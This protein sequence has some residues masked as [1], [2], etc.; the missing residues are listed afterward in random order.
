MANSTQIAVRDADIVA[1]LD[2]WGENN[3][4]DLFQGRSFQA[5]KQDAALAIIE[6]N[7]LR[8]CMTSEKGRL[9]L[10]RALQRSATSG[11][12]LNPQK[13]ESALV[14]INGEVNFWPM[15]NGIIKT[16]LET[17]ALEYVEANTIYS[18]DTFS[19]KKTAR[20]DDYDF[21]PSLKDRGFPA[22]YF[23]V[24]VLKSGRSVV[25]YWDKQQVEDHKKKYG[26]GLTNPKSAW[27]N[28]FDGMAEK[29]VLKALLAGLHL[30][31][32]VARLIEMDNAVEQEP[33]RDV[34]ETQSCEK[35]ADAGGIEAKLA[36]RAAADGETGNG[37]TAAPEGKPASDEALF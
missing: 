25:E 11:L 13:G 28:N 20:G 36:A 32:A 27:N 23:A 5:W 6:N 9:S 33:E 24:A 15:K 14:P 8:A 3:I 31:S 17:G 29:T 21:S 22:A 34:T 30:P 4:V 19:I 18:G 35:G 7:D 10:V 2:K 12:S 1:S 26:K 16:A 37:N